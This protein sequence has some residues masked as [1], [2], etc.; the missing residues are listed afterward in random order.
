[1]SDKNI[2]QS[3]SLFK[4]PVELTT[5]Q[6]TALTSA[7]RWLGSKRPKPFFKLEG[8]AGTGKTTL[9]TELGRQIPGVVYAAFTGKAASILRHKGGIDAT[10][11]HRLLYQ[12]PTIKTDGQGRQE[13]IFEPKA[14]PIDASLIVADECSMIG[15]A[16]GG[17][18]LDHG[19]PVLVTGDGYQ[20]PPIA[21]A[22]F[23]DAKP[24][25][26]LTEIHRQAA[27]S[28]P[29]ALATKIRSGEPITVLPFD[30][31][32]MMAADMVIVALNKTLRLVNRLWQQTCGADY[33]RIE[34]RYPQISETVLCLKTNYRSGVLNGE[35]WRVE[36]CQDHNG[37]LRLSLI[38]DLDAKATVWV[39]ENDFL[40]GPRQRQVDDDEF[41]SFDFG[42]AATA[43]KAQGSEWDRVCVIDET[44]SRGFKWVVRKSGL[45]ADEFSR[46]WL[47]TAVTRA[48]RHVDI[49]EA[50]P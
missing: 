32:K 41:D 19:V 28:Q 8:Y 39:P 23:F 27:G 20:L 11:L 22:P 3:K 1:L 4:S 34:H 9:V 50:P 45:S 16:L 12:P 7:Q 44:A 47:Y 48:S 24:D 33:S 30:R 35:I 42:Y 17:E 15:L 21:D 29:L 5:Q 2:R 40:Q 26:V 37:F 38:D 10:T 49:M 18:L 25:F 36:D 46:R 14:E 31:D 13:L 6:L 43:H